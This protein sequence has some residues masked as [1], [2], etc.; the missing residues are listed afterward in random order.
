MHD[1]LKHSGTKINSRAGDTT[2]S[3]YSYNLID[4]Q[5]VIQPTIPNSNY[6]NKLLKHVTLL[7][8]M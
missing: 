8:V 5:C 2:D 3:N 7:H 1:K 6:S 4:S